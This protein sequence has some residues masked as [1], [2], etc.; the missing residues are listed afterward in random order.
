MSMNLRMKWLGLAGLAAGAL[1][2]GACVGPDDD[3]A[4]EGAS[5]VV[6]DDALDPASG[7]VSVKLSIDQAAV[8]ASESPFVTITFTNTARHAVK[9]LAWYAPSEELEEDLFSVSLGG[10]PVEYI[11]PH[12][13]RPAP[14]KED[15]IVLAPGKSLTRDVNL[16]DFYDLSQT[17]DYTIRYSAELSAQNVEKIAVMESNQASLWIKGRAAAVPGGASA[18]TS[19]DNPL[20]VTGSL[21]FTKCT[22]DQQTTVKDAL[23]AASV[24]ADGAVN[25]LGGTPTASARYTT[26]FGAF[27]TNGWNTAKS[28]MVAVK[29]AID[30]KSLTFNCGCKKQYYAYVYPNQPYEIYLCSVFWKAPLSGTDSKGGTL[31]HEL[32]HFTVI[33]GTDDYAYGQSAAK[34]LA[35][36]D[37]NKAL[38]NADNHEY[39]SENTPS[40][41]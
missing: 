1:L 22:A 37:P 14:Q 33:A 13:K 30:T 5:E 39:F 8:P 3:G 25:Y 19:G 2:I 17:G 21:A 28:H 31:I 41:Q 10:K 29:D 16:S 9:L 6:G 23:N 11:G 18:S 36:S 35:G 20:Y 34:S 32:S 40:L 24:M 38:F 12:Y 27:S 26:W 15:F 4:P 7:D